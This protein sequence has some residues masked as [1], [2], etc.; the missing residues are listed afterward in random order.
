MESFEETKILLAIESM[1]DWKRLA[2]MAYCCERM[3][4]NYRNFNAETGYGDV[5]V[6]RSALDAAWAWIE[7]NQLSGNVASLVSDCERQAP[8][9]SEFSS[10]YTS[11]ALDAATAT[12]TTLEALTTA[13]AKQVIEVASL[14]RDTVDLFVQEKKDLDPNDPR[15]EM[16]I[17]ESGLMQAE[18][19]MQR[20]SLE[21]L[22]NLQEQRVVAS[23]ELRTRWSNLERGSLN[24]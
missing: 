20:Q 8:D 1:P 14:A 11:A 9:T 22:K 2:F 13:T 19:R 18:L 24:S 15:L 3:L 12:A 4:P 10:T 6:L 5:L 17:I 7:T 21:T 16:K 23:R